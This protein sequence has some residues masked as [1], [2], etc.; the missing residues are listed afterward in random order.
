[1]NAVASH[2]RKVHDMPHHHH[3]GEDE[4]LWS[5]LSA[6][7]RFPNLAPPAIY[8]RVAVGLGPDARH[9][10]APAT[11]TNAAAVPVAAGLAL[12]LIWCS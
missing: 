12:Q 11:G 1:M 9:E 4:L 7:T 6:R 10:P 2:A 5:K 8:I 3:A